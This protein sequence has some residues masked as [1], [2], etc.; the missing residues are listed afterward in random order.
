M[1]VLIAFI[2]IPLQI[3]SQAKLEFNLDNWSNVLIQAQ[4]EKKLIYLDCYTSWCAPCKRMD[5]EVF[6][7]KEV[8]KLYGENFI[9]YKMDMENGIGPELVKQYS[10][11]VYPTH[12]FINGE[13]TL[14]HRGNGFKTPKEF[15]EF[16]QQ[17]LNPAKQTSKL[18]KEYSSGNRSPDFLIIYIKYLEKT[19]QDY[20]LVFDEYLS[21]IP[22][23]DLSK[24]ETLKLLYQY[25]SHIKTN[26]F[27]I[28]SNKLD[29]I[30]KLYEP[31]LLEFKYFKICE[32]SVKIAAKSNDEKFLDQIAQLYREKIHHE[33]EELAIYEYI[34]ISYY[35]MIKD[36][37]KMLDM[38][39]SYINKFI[40]NGENIDSYN[41]EL[42]N[43]LRKGKRNKVW[44]YYD[45]RP[46]KVIHKFNENA[47]KLVEFSKI[48]YYEEITDTSVQKAAI[49]W[50]NFS[51]SIEER[52]AYYDLLIRLYYRTNSMDLAKRY[53]EK[54]LVLAKKEKYQE[55]DYQELLEIERNLNNH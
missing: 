30:K 11:K 48:I 26:A 34:Y 39:L 24:E 19:H 32:Q 27:E 17:A 52:F 45:T 46:K 21:E 43:Q 36:Y 35:R 14:V 8:I 49:N 16:G 47:Y 3:F 29:L 10:V 37:K 40:T 1:R 18:D 41:K 38:M 54:A 9:N 4:Q 13:G 51:I 53:I 5:K 12:L 44:F 50:I 22:E 20:S 2:V 25:T 55:E 7:S 33:N 23:P 42:L 28:F 31:K 15:I 6:T